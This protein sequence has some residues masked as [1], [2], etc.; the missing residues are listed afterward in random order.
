MVVFHCHVS[1]GGGVFLL[2]PSINWK[3]IVASPLPP[4]EVVHPLSQWLVSLLA[5][6]P[7]CQ[8]AGF[9]YSCK[10][11]Q[12]LNAIPLHHAP[13]HVMASSQSKKETNHF[14]TNTVFT[15]SQYL[16]AAAKQPTGLPSVLHVVT[17]AAEIMSFEPFTMF[18]GSFTT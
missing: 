7:F 17:S 14:W 12:R 15:Q 2:T 6:P 13:I 4:L 1:F 10:F 8:K 16:H 5:C 3:T 9:L 18:Y 11:P